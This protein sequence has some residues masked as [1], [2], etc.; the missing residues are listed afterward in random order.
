MRRNGWNVLSVLQFVAGILLF[1]SGL[2]ELMSSDD[3]WWWNLL[4]LLVGLGAMALA[5]RMARGTG[6]P[7]L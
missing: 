2:F 7:T 1:A 4:L 5:V 3:R 6:R